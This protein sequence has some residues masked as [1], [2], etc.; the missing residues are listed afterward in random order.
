VT[1]ESARSLRCESD[2][3]AGVGSRKRH[4][5][6]STSRF[7]NSNKLDTSFDMSNDETHNTGSMEPAR[8]ESPRQLGLT[9]T[10]GEYNR[11][12]SVWLEKPGE[13]P[14]AIRW[15]AKPGFPGRRLQRSSPSSQCNE[16][17]F[18]A[19]R[20]PQ[21]RGSKRSRT[22]VTMSSMS[23]DGVSALSVAADASLSR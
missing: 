7:A 22:A 3:H 9:E 2:L 5:P 8:L 14:G 20:L 4:S 18:D 10:R 16:G 1:P 17:C 19:P 13:K 23:I 11:K 15:L 12:F 21:G 6:G